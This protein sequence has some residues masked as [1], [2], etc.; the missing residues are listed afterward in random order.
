[1]TFPINFLMCSPDHYDVDYVINPWM[2]GNVHKSSR[3]RAVEQWQGLFQI[4]KEYATVELV[5]PQIGWPDM[6]F[7]ANAGLVLGNNVVLSRFLHKERQGEEPYFKQWFE[8]QG[9]T[10]HE[11]PQDLSFEGAGDA[12][13]DREGRWLWAGY[14]F[15]SQ[16][17]SHSYLAKWLDIEV[18]S[19]RLVDERFYHLDTCFCP[20]SGGYLL[21]YPAAFD[22]YS[23]RLIE[24]RVPPEKRIAIQEADAVNFAC[25]TV[26]ID[27]VVIMNKASDELKNRLTAVGFQVIETPLTEFL[28]AGGAAKCLTLRVTEP[29]RKPA[30][31]PKFSVVIPAYNVSAYIADCVNSVLAQTETDFEVIVVDDGSTDDTAQIVS[32]FVDPRV[33]LVRR[34]NGGLATARNTG[35]RAAI[36]EFV[37]FLDADDRWCPEKLA[38][39]RQ[40]LE[41]DPN[42]SVS[43]DWSVFINKQGERT[44]LSMAQT[45]KVITHEALLLKNYLG[46]GST[47]VVRRSVL[48]QTGGFDE[49]LRRFVDHELWVRLAFHGHHFRLV[50]HQLTEY[51]IHP[52]SFTADTQ[53]M[54]KGLEAFLAKIATYAPDSIK[55]LAPLAIACTHRWMAR[56]AFVEGNYP[57]AYQHALQALRTSPQVLWRDQRAPIT[58][59]A[60]FLQAIAPK[61]IFNGMLQLG[62]RFATGWFQDRSKKNQILW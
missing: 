22:A 15:R 61:P 9:Y 5:P 31:T 40:A 29:V 46:N 1:M 20:L 17:D 39:H 59:A 49:S 8:S 34:S 6:V 50:P 18:L 53:R 21:Y 28:K 51:R 35:I 45:Q 55:R 57:K 16:L 60:I 26:N 7:T 56:A 30:H 44:G 38:A 32:S 24:M 12:L 25:N 19:L 4:I 52:A 54:L 37:A 48:E 13:L 27:S 62:H 41:Q 23:N 43:Y 14:G 2:E 42:A 3:D 47:A 33:H 58:F 36:G 10:V 11:L